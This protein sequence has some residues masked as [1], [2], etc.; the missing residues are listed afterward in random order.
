[1]GVRAPMRSVITGGPGAGKSSLLS[2]LGAAGV[3]TFPEVAR[4]ILQAPGGMA[5]RAECPAKFAEAMIGA[6]RDSWDA[7][8]AGAVI[9]DRGF[10]DIVGFLHL[11]GLPIP[12]ELDRCCRKLRYDGPIFRAP[13]WRDIYV[14]DAQRIQN[15]QEAIASDAAI[16]AAWRSFGYELIDLPRVP[17]PVRLAFVLNSLEMTDESDR[18]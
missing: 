7:T 18:L 15:W 14:P 2:A 16:C 12:D 8:G 10:P 13:P 1:M 5:L 3:A 6:Q 9:C 17:V 4:T 11:E